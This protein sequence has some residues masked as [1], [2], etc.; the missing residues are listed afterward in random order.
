MR[1]RRHLSHRKWRYLAR[2]PPL[3]AAMV[4]VAQRL[5]V[6]LSCAIWKSRIAGHTVALAVRIN[7]PLLPTVSL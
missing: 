7:Y 6:G 5:A 3:K 4:S 2:F 1:S